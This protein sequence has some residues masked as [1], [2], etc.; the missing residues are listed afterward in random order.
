KHFLCEYIKY[1]RIKDLC[2]KNKIEYIEVANK[3]ELIVLKEKIK[4]YNPEILAASTF[5]LKIPAEILELFRYA[6]NVHPSLL[7]K[8]RGASPIMWALV[9][10]EK[11]TGVSVHLITDEYDAGDIIDQIQIPI[12]SEDT[13]AT[14]SARIFDIYAPEIL[15][16][17]LTNIKLSRITPKKQNTAEASYFRKYTIDDSFIDFEKMEAQK[18]CRIV[19]AGNYYYPAHFNLGEEII[20]IWN[21]EFIDRDFDG[22]AAGEIVGIAEDNNGLI[23]QTLKKSVNIKVLQKNLPTIAPLIFGRQLLELV[24]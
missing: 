20:I 16:R 17:V 11:L 24:K 8:Y 1:N 3:S 12:D 5:H 13:A 21:A 4:T 2:A 22:F 14:L 6:I 18:I 15:I 9:N 7:P 23:V 10:N 19:K